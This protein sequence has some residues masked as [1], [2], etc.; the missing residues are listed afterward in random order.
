MD[1]D[2]LKIKVLKDKDAHMPTYAHNGDAGCDLSSTE[3]ST[4]KPGERKLIGT[5]IRI[6]L[7]IGFEA[8]IRPRSGLAHKHGVSIVN[9]PGTVDAG[10]RGE[11]K[12]NLINLGQEPFVVEKGMRI[13]QMVINKVE[14]ARFIEVDELE[15]SSRGEGGYGSTG[16]K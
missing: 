13:A 14:H 16:V 11:I 8:Q 6:A 15:E 2:N 10:Y 4:L 1:I 5:G 9:A 7:P 12:V 3:D